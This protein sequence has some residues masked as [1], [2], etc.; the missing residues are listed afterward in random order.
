MTNT[1]LKAQIDSQITNETLPNSI[2]PADVGGNLKSV[3]DYTDQEVK[4]KVLK[5]IITHNELLNIF[6]TPIVLLPATS[7]KAFIPKDIV[8]KYI[9]NDGWSSAGTWRVL[10]DTT[11]LTNFTSQMG[12]T[13]NKEQA[14]YLLLG[15]PSNTATSFFNK[16]VSFTS[17]AN[18]T[19]PVNPNTTAVVYLTYFEILE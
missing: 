19:S 1:A 7:G 5:R 4:F 12:G 17:S 3:V 2:S 11:Q 14:T 13:A 9:D 8:I 16:N 15:N 10:L 18:P 6:T